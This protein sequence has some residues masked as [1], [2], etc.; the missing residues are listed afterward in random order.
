[1][2]MTKAI[3]SLNRIIIVGM[4]TL[5]MGASLRALG[6]DNSMY[7]KCMGVYA[8][9]GATGTYT[10]WYS[11]GVRCEASEKVYKIDQGT[12]K[13]TVSRLKDRAKKLYAMADKACRSSIPQLSQMG[14]K[15]NKL[16]EG[17][18]AQCL[19]QANGVLTKSMADMDAYKKEYAKLVQD[20]N[21]LRNGSQ[22]ALEMAKRTGNHW[23]RTFGLGTGTYVPQGSR[24]TG[25]SSPEKRF[26]AETGVPAKQWQSASGGGGR[27]A[28]D[29]K[30]VK[31]INERT[32]SDISGTPESIA[33]RSK[34]L[35]LSWKDLQQVRNPIIQEHLTNQL[36]AE[37]FKLRLRQYE[38]DAQ[39]FKTQ[40]SALKEKNNETIRLLE[41][42][43][44]VAESFSANSEGPRSSQPKS[45]RQA[46]S[47]DV[48]APVM[49]SPRGA[50]GPSPNYAPGATAAAT[51]PEE[52]EAEPL[53]AFEFSKVRD[54]TNQEELGS[55]AKGKVAESS[56]AGAEK[57]A[58]ASISEKASASADGPKKVK[59]SALREALRRKLAMGGK[60]TKAELD[61][62]KDAEAEE[63]KEQLAAGGAPAAGTDG[64]SRS[65]AS[66][67][68]HDD[69]LGSFGGGLET[70]GFS[71][72]GVEAETSA[73]DIVSDF[74][75]AL[76]ESHQES[77]DYIG[78]RDSSPLF[79]R[80][81]HYHDRCLRSGCVSLSIK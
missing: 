36:E 81:K 5:A 32:E 4:G 49:A 23:D 59:S 19:R 51:Q 35:D 44:S 56:P 34:D 18:D 7:W 27:A 15:L 2:R 78:N 10:N 22:R 17:G 58:E 14:C 42:A 45:D 72:G 64:A 39:R 9:S 79:E 57:L 12:C 13:E 65:P 53:L 75:A 33:K 73:Q 67:G 80:V 71:F 46:A 24:D 43:G 3:H 74:E 21:V 63:A 77:L 66:T 52:K 76:A 31:R 11:N 26:E 55:E 38:S 48:N 25:K 29:E 60:A 20:I 50:P 69:L 47:N 28:D 68:T 37:E 54:Y 30:I 61:A 70:G 8:P 1:M 62:I 16:G 40:A 6:A 41:S